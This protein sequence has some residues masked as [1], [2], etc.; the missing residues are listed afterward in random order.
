MPK[1]EM[2]SA[3]YE[4]IADKTLSFGSKITMRKC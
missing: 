3:I 2:I 1:E 4:K